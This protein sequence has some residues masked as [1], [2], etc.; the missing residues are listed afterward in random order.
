MRTGWAT[1]VQKGAMGEVLGKIAKG[2]T[3]WEGN[4]AGCRWEY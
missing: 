2:S 3:D 4:S 1:S